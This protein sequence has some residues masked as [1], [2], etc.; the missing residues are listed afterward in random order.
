M[1]VNVLTDLINTVGFPIV[2]SGVL[3]YV[4]YDMQK[5]YASAIADITDALN[6]NTEVINKILTMLEEE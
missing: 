1:D 5:R 4:I 2:V 3:L 6:H